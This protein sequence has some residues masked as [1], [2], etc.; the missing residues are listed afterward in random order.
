[1]EKKITYM[2]QLALVNL[3]TCLDHA[4]IRQARN[5]ARR[6]KLFLKNSNTARK[7]LV[8]TNLLSLH[9]KI[10]QFT[11]KIPSKSKYFSQY[12]KLIS[13]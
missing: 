4:A 10:K 11:L 2:T 9:Y 7:N 5:M 3:G 6:Y 8:L 13:H 12:E 1:M